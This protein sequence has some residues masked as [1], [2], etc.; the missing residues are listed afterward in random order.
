MLCFI[1][2]LFACANCQGQHDRHDSTTRLTNTTMAICQMDSRCSPSV[3]CDKVLVELTKQACFCTQS[4]RNNANFNAIVTLFLANMFKLFFCAPNQKLAS[5]LCTM[6]GIPVKIADWGR[7]LVYARLQHLTRYHLL[8]WMGFCIKQIYHR[9]IL[10]KEHHTVRI[11]FDIRDVFLIV[12]I[13]SL[14][15]QLP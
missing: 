15:V 10:S 4:S 9:E 12:K 6:D 13:K 8:P 7:Q 1:Q 14:S 3:H 2:K 11:T 5:E